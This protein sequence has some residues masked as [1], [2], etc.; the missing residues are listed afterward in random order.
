MVSKVMERRIN[1]D[2]LPLPKSVLRLLTK[3]GFHPQT[4]TETRRIIEMDLKKPSLLETLE[5]C[6]QCMAKLG[7]GGSPAQL[8]LEIKC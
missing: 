6:G 7:M 2:A 5:L 4:K 8:T 3:A 1:R